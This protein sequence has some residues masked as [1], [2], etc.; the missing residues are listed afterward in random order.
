MANVFT[1][2]HCLHGTVAG[3]SVQVRDMCTG[4][5]PVRVVQYM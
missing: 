3:G 2:Q 4:T 5:V 1:I